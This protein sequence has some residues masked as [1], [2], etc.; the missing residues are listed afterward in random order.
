M[1]AQCEYRVSFEMNP[2][3]MISV[4]THISLIAFVFLIIKGISIE[5]EHGIDVSSL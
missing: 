3:F 1:N 5:M 4:C 2:G